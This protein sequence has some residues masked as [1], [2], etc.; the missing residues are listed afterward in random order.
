MKYYRITDEN[1]SWWIEYRTAGMQNSIREK[2]TNIKTSNSDP[3]ELNAAMIATG[4][5][6]HLGDEVLEVELLALCTTK[7]LRISKF[8]EREAEV[9]LRKSSAK[10]ILTFTVPTQVGATVI[11]NGASGSI[12]INVENDTVL[13]AVIPTFTVTNRSYVSCPD[14]DIDVVESEVT[15]L[16]FTDALLLKVWD[17]ALTDYDYDVTLTKLSKTAQITGFT[18]PNQTGGSTINQGAGTI[19]ITVPFGTAV[20]ALVPT[21]TKSAGSTISPAVAATNFTSPVVFTV[22]SQDLTVEKEYTVTI[23]VAAE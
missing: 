4:L 13:T 17:E 9:A 6:V 15:E 19:A 11:T 16:D 8:Y 1:E 20:T 23:T 12:A 5:P 21:V 7:E 2:I 10:E 22:T 18:V 3:L 14:D